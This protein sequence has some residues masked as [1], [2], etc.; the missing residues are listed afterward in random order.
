MIFHSY[1]KLPEGSW[2]MNFLQSVYSWEIKEGIRLEWLKS[3]KLKKKESVHQ[4]VSHHKKRFT[5]V[6]STLQFQRSPGPLL[7]LCRDDVLG[8]L[9]SP[10]GPGKWW[11][12]YHRCNILSNPFFFKYSVWYIEHMVSYIYI[13]THTPFFSLS[14]L[15]IY[16]YIHRVSLIER[17]LHRNILYM[18]I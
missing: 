4:D 15:Y 11:V 6:F 17:N 13:Y 16:I 12:I 2:I 9:R 5:M 1:V 3:W 8:I 10:G 18:N 7:H 14:M